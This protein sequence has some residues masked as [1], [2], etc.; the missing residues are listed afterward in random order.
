MRSAAETGESAPYRATSHRKVRSTLH[1]GPPPVSLLYVVHNSPAQA[2]DQQE[3]IG[4]LG[5][6]RDEVESPAR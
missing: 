6:I 2:I 5:R 4:T 1:L 3:W